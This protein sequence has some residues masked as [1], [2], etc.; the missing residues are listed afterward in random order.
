M[1]LSRPSD[2]PFRSYQVPW[3]LEG[4]VV[5]E[6]SCHVL[7]NCLHAPMMYRLGPGLSLL[8]PPGI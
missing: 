7:L 3:V 2:H 1:A 5:L 8:I 6:L 4:I